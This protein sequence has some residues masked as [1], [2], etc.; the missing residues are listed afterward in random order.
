LSD[1]PEPPNEPHEE[2]STESPVVQPDDA[3]AA[4]EPRPASPLVPVL[5]MATLLLL[6]GL[7]FLEPAAGLLQAPPKSRFRPIQ[8]TTRERVEH[9]AVAGLT[10]LWFFMLGASLGSFL[11]C[12]EYRLPRGISIAA[13]GSK[14]PG[15]GT[16]IRLW[17]NIPVLGWLWLRGRCAHCGW[18]IPS[19]YALTEFVLGTVFVVLMAV[20][21]IGGGINLPPLRDVRSI[22][23][24]Q[25]LW[26][27][28]WRLIA[29]FAYHAALLCLLT[30]W[31]LFAV[32]RFRIPPSLL[33]IGLAIGIGSALA[34][35]VLHPV[36]WDGSFSTADPWRVRTAIDLF[37]GALAGLIVGGLLVRHWP[38]NRRAG[39]A[40]STI[41]G[42]LLVGLFLGWQ[43]AVGV[44]AITTALRV[45]LLI[46]SSRKWPVVVSIAIAALLHLLGW[47]VLASQWWWPGPLSPWYVAPIYAALVAVLSQWIDSVEQGGDAEPGVAKA[48]RTEPVS[49]APEVSS[50]PPEL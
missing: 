35:P 46:S 1:L 3:V 16:P 20:E 5:A 39:D 36:G 27:P 4:P 14:C 47:S 41:L 6:V 43:A 50:L 38:G 18:T 22:G 40:A 33:A 13:S 10:A 12:V 31:S 23:L 29:T 17:H 19:R 9:G 44:A 34:W 48:A 30:T 24:V 49:A 28:D 11:H 25:N 2:E 21:I 42:M 32:D 8:L 26:D 7:F 37:A 15:C 45:L